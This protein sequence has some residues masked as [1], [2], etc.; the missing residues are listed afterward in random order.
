[1][2]WSKMRTSK[3]SKT[4]TKTVTIIDA[5]NGN[6]C[7]SFS[8][9]A[10]ELF[11]V[12]RE[13]GIPESHYSGV[14]ITTSGY[15]GELEVTYTYQVVNQDYD[16]QMLEF[17]ENEARVEREMQESRVREAQSAASAAA[18]KAY[19]DFHRAQR[20]VAKACGRHC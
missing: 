3:P 20:V 2:C 16:S 8:I 4:L 7:S 11:F 12:L 10:Q 19:K 17:L 15:E 1:M 14:D 18:R 9:T 5:L 6:T 13:R